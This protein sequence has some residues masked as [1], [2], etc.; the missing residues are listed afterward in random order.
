MLTKH[1]KSHDK[2]VL[3]YSGRWSSFT[4]ACA[5]TLAQNILQSSA[6]AA[7]A[8]RTCH[9]LSNSDNI[10]E[11]NPHLTGGPSGTYWSDR[12]FIPVPVVLGEAAID[13]K[14]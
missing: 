6:L 4:P 14:I 13:G 9:P 10:S 8:L 2:S 1:A 11:L 12:Y 3:L 7:F 5:D